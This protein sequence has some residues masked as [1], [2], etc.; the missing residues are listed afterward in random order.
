[1]VLA[2]FPCPQLQ[3]VCNPSPCSRSARRCDGRG[4]WLCYFGGLFQLLVGV[5]MPLLT[6]RTVPGELGRS[7]PVEEWPRRPGR[8][9]P[10]AVA[11]L[12]AAVQE[13][14][15]PTQGCVGGSQPP[16]LRK[17]PLQ[18]RGPSDAQSRVPSTV[19]EAPGGCASSARDARGEPGRPDTP[20]S[21]PRCWGERS[22][23]GSVFYI[24]I[25]IF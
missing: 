9:A 7:G 18:W 23:L 25:K 12:R 2:P 6:S 17:S 13:A 1:M 22:N 19:P 4:L 20:C 15:G 5:L 24:F 16:L 21:S 3:E 11:A 10:G 8:E 14:R